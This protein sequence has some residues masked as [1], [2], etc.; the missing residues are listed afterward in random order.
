MLT[1]VDYRAVHE[2]ADPEV[3]VAEFEV[4]GERTGGAEPFTFSDVVVLRARGGEILSLRDYWSPL[5]RVDPHAPAEGT[6]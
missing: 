6:R 2:T 4:H 5:D 3:V 1:G